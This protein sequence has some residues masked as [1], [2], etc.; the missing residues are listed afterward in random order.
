VFSGGLA[1]EIAAGIKVEVE[2]SL[3]GGVLT[4]TKVHFKDNIRIESNTTAAGATITAVAGL[5]GVT[6]SANSFTE[7][8]NS[9]ATA[10]DLSSLNGRNVRIRGRASGASSVIATEIEDRGAADP[11]TD[12]IL[13]GPATNVAN[14]TLAIL[15]VPVDTSLLNSTGD[16]KDVNDA[17]ISRTVFFDGL[18][19]NGILVKAKGRL[20][21]TAGNNEL[22]AGELREIELEN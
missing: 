2:G 7:F 22:S 9:L 3:S 16:F 19:A 5:P 12:V 17:P 15:G 20:P 4:A 10:S 21:T 13:Q 8:K 1:S 6:V 14:P 11:G 18:A